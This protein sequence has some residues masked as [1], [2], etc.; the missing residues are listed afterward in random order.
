MRFILTFSFTFLFV[1]CFAQD[2]VKYGKDIVIYM[3]D[4]VVQKIFSSSENYIK[5]VFEYNDCGILI[6]RWW[7][8]K[9]GKLL[10]VT[11]DN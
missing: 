5:I 1:I 7:Y 10:S 3:N 9:N 2:T 4:K 6:R 11:L 8:D